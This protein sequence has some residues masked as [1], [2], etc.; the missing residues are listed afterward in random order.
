MTSILNDYEID[1]LKNENAR[2]Y[3][4][5]RELRKELEAVKVENKDLKIALQDFMAY[6]A[7]RGGISDVPLGPFERGREVLNVIG[8]VKPEN[9]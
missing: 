9:S 8:A 2:L 6:Y 3:D 7:P 1:N 5:N 4:E